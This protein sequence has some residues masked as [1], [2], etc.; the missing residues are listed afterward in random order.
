MGV[1]SC[2]C[3]IG[4]VGHKVDGLVGYWGEIRKGLQ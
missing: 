3:L 4:S 2:G 1:G